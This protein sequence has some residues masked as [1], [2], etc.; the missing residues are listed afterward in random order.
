MSIEHTIRESTRVDEAV[1]QAVLPDGLR[2]RVIP[3][4]GYQKKFAVLLADYGSIDTAFVPAGAASPLETPA[5][6][7]H[8]LEHKLFED[9]AGDVFNQF[10]RYGASA[11]AYTSYTE[12]AYHFT[13]T[14][15]FTTCLDLLLRFVTDPYFTE[16]QIRK[17]RQVIAQEI[18]TYE[19]SPGAMGHLDLLKA[20]Y[21]QHP[22]RVDITGTVESIEAIDK[23]LLEQCHGAF[24]RAD[25]LLLVVAGDVEPERVF[26]QAAAAERAG[27]TGEAIGRV[28]VEEPEGVASARTERAMAVSLPRVALGIKVAPQG[29]GPGMIRFQRE[30]GFLLELVFG[31]SSRFFEE[32]CATGLIDDTFHASLDLGRGGFAHVVIGGESPDPDRL[33]ATVEAEIARVVEAGDLGEADFVRLRNKAWGRYLRS[34]NSLEAIA[35]GEADSCLQGWDLLTYLDLLETITLEGVAARGARVLGSPHRAVSLVVPQ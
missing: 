28:T 22:V 2:V 10:A 16:E 26:E 1:H 27:A 3:K 15:H 24:Y 35:A 8:F 25:N 34:F 11:N 17:E 19:D 9:E 4:P 5:G 29:V 18:R 7:A 6:V 32:H 30:V 14:S 13:T 21:H 23:P 31:R 33:V 12:T 20:L